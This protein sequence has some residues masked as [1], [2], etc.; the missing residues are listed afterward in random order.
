MTVEER[1]ERLERRERGWRW[2]AGA[3]VLLAVCSALLPPVQAQGGGGLA[4][5]PFR[6]VDR[7]GN[8]V[9]EVRREAGET[10][11]AL[12]GADDRERLRLS[13]GAAG[14]TVTGL[15]KSGAPGFRL[16]ATAEGAY[17]VDL[18]KQGQVRLFNSGTAPQVLLRTG[19]EGAGIITANPEGKV[20]SALL[21]TPRGG[22]LH[23]RRANGEPWRELVPLDPD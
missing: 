21:S 23:L 13:V 6:I 15:E 14:S 5:A 3:G 4:R 17:T 18:L 8:R 16:G 10:V 22:E 9:L 19:R 12:V 11:L 2:L 7:E 1:L 20:H